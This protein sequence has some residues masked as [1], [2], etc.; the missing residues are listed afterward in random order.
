M[1]TIKVDVSDG[2]APIPIRVFIN[3][4]ENNEDDSKFSR[5]E[6]FEESFDLNGG[7]YSILVT[8]KNNPGSST[9][10][11]VSGECLAGP[12]PSKP[13]KRV[14]PSYAVLFNLEV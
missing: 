10:I 4:L 13:Q 1:V 9:Q 3:H 12:V 7:K 14:K 2:I 11:S 8:G 5:D 6:S